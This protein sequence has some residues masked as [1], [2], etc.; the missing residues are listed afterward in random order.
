MRQPTLLTRWNFRRPPKTPIETM[1]GTAEF[2]SAVPCEVEKYH[3]ICER[4]LIAALAKTGMDSEYAALRRKSAG[5]LV[6][7]ETWS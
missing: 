3:P 7:E 6:E 5:S 1:Q 4:A 2:T